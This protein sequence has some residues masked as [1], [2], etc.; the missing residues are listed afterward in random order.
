MVFLVLGFLCTLW[1][2]IIS[3]ITY[4]LRVIVGLAKLGTQ[5]D[6]LGYICQIL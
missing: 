4:H 2:L 5:Y 6:A 3:N 1:F